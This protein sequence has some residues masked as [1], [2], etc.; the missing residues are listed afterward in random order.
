MTERR[1]KPSGAD[2]VLVA[3]VGL[4]GP[5]LIRLLGRTWRVTT[6]GDGVIDGV[7]ASGRAAI[8]AFWHGQLLALEYLYRGRK[9]H[10]LSSWHRDGEISARLMT[11]LGFGVIRGSTSRGSARGLLGIFFLAEKSGAAIVPVA[12]AARPSKRLS[13]WDRFIVPLPFSRVS[14]VFGDPIDPDAQASFGEKSR[15]LEEVLSRLTI[16]ARALAGGRAHEAPPS[17]PTAPGAP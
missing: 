3:L 10:V 13:S 7:H 14:V 8:Y 17:A 16:K 11:A 6:A 4:L 5:A 9:I 2:R 15:A 1:A 12:V